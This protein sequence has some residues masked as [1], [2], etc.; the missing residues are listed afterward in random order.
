MMASY[1]TSFLMSSFD[2]PS[3]YDSYFFFVSPIEVAQDLMSAAFRILR[4]QDL[5]DYL[6]STSQSTSAPGDSAPQGFFKWFIRRF[7]LG[8]PLIGAGSLVH[9]LLSMQALL[10]VQWLA[11]Y[12]GRRSRRNSNGDIAAIIVLGLIV[13]GALRALHKVYKLTESYVQK[14]LLRAEDAILEVN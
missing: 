1:V 7:L 13:L 10:P 5:G 9:M 8:L 14:M 2:Q 11:R 6:G 12:R 4:D 3:D